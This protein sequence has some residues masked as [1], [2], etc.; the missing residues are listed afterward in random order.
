MKKVGNSFV[1]MKRNVRYLV[2][3]SCLTLAGCM[4]SDKEC[5]EQAYD[6]AREARAVSTGDIGRDPLGTIAAHRLIT[7]T[8]GSGSMTLWAAS[9]ISRDAKRKEI[10]AQRRA[11]FIEYSKTDEYKLRRQ[12][13]IECN[14]R[15]HTRLVR[16]RIHRGKDVRICLH[17]HEICN[18]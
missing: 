10:K 18:N 17:D 4:C 6:P 12:I 9:T 13:S 14:D 11:E 7:G 15:S 8:G 2:L 1:V 16:C 5:R 3:A